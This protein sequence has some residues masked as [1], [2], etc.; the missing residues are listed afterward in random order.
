M[1]LRTRQAS[2]PIRAASCLTPR[3]MNPSSRNHQHQHL[4]RGTKGAANTLG[5]ALAVQSRNFKLTSCRSPSLLVDIPRS[6]ARASCLVHTN[7]V[8]ELSPS[9][10]FDIGLERH[11][12]CEG[13]VEMLRSSQV[14]RAVLLCDYRRSNDLNISRTSTASKIWS[15]G[16]FGRPPGLTV[17]DAA[18]ATLSRSPQPRRLIRPV[19]S[20]SDRLF[21][22]VRFCLIHC[23]VLAC[24]SLQSLTRYPC[25]AGP[26]HGTAAR[27]TQLCKCFFPICFHLRP[28]SLMESDQ[29]VLLDFDTAPPSVNIGAVRGS[30][31]CTSTGRNAMISTLSSSSTAELRCALSIAGKRHSQAVR[32]CRNVGF[33]AF[34][35]LL[36][37]CGMPAGSTHALLNTIVH[38]R[39]CGRAG[40]ITVW[41]ANGA[42]KPIGAAPN[43]SSRRRAAASRSGGVHS[44]F[45]KSLMDWWGAAGP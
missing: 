31:R 29:S 14:H 45:A 27:V 39:R 9:V 30:R 33:L 24:A 36:V 15:S 28:A 17:T 4:R 16:A 10:L 32:H 3:I 37:V 5:G 44:T 1:C 26:L 6:R 34:A 21:F 38:L 22:R 41:S 8:H 42:V 18:K 13:S 12:G 40:V 7:K 43:I 11:G 35:V 25:A 2:R 19:R 23:L 20:L